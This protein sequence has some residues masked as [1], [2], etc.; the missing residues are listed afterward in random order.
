[1][2]IDL[3]LN[4]G[5]YSFP[6]LSGTFNL[7]G[8]TGNTGIDTDI[9]FSNSLAGIGNSLLGWL[10]QGNNATDLLKYGLAGIGI[11]NQNKNY[12]DQLEEARRQFQFAQG[13]TRAN[14]MNQGT[15][16]L[17]QSLFQLEALN[18]FNPNASAERAANLGAAV[19]QLNKAGSL[20]GLGDN[21]FE[22]QANAIAK[23]NELAKNRL[24]SN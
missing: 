18:A 12:E 15:N 3:S 14:F 8:L 11:W 16:F 10:G 21:A 9:T 6:G 2:A 13:N 24:A 17:N 20:I 23:Y 5:N 4:T 7:N 22:S 19:N 1:M